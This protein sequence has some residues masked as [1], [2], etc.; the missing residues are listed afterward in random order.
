MIPDWDT[1]EESVWKQTTKEETP[2]HI[3]WTN[4]DYNCEIHRLDDGTWEY[5]ICWKDS[6]LRDGAGYKEI[7]DAIE[8]AYDEWISV[9]TEDH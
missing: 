6:Y 5:V 8:A 7:D 3:K 2:N 4:S 9:F 1:Y